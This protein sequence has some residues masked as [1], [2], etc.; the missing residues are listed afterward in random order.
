VAEAL[1]WLARKSLADYRLTDPPRDNAF[2][3]YSRLRDIEPGEARRGILE[4]ANRFALL[5]ERELAS[6]RYQEAR[7][8]V[9]MG[10]HIDPANASLLALKPLT[11]HPPRGLIA[12]LA[13]LFSR[14]RD[15][16]QVER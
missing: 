13:D 5:A 16:R 12:R 15:G 4:I 3:Y 2:Y 11:D 9:G 8:Y 6:Q 10:L 7:G 14:D 1:R